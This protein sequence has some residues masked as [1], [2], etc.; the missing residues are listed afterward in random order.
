ML[1]SCGAPGYPCAQQIPDRPI[2]AGRINSIDDLLHEIAHVVIADARKL[3]LGYLAIWR[4]DL[5]VGKIT[6]L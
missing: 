5:Y 1:P 2:E 6:R 3:V 4:H